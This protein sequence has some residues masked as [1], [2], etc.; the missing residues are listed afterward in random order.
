MDIRV[1]VHIPGRK[2]GSRIGIVRFYEAGYYPT[3]LDNQ[4][5]TAEQVE[6]FVNSFNASGGI[7]EDVARSAVEASMFGWHV[8]AAKPA[9]E[10]FKAKDLQREQFNK[11]DQ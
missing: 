6:E 2:P 11:G 3:D 8:P 4:R 9:T 1:A 10:F 5:W 7:P